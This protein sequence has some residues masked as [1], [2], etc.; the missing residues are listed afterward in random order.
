MKTIS[1]I[2]YAKTVKFWLKDFAKTNEK[3][4]N[5]KNDKRA[6]LEKDIID[7]RYFQD[8]IEQKLYWNWMNYSYDLMK[9]LNCK[10]NIRQMKTYINMYA[11]EEIENQ[12]TRE[13][14]NLNDN[15][16]KSFTTIWY[17]ENYEKV[18]EE[19]K[20]LLI[21]LVTYCNE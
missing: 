10:A 11:K 21:N 12:L 9:K 3:Y 17:L 14:E 16:K 1:L 18:N 7:Y 2:D 6:T 19:M 8:N 15:E 4:G 20:E 13:N 5:Y